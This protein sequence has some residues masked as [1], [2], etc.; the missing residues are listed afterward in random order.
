MYGFLHCGLEDVFE[1][2]Q[3]FFGEVFGKRRGDYL[4]VCEADLG[5]ELFPAGRGGGKNYSLI[6]QGGYKGEL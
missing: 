4:E 5:E 2:G 3:R 6:L 1:R